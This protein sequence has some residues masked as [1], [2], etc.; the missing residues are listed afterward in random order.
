MAVQVRIQNFQSLK[1][2]G[3]EISGFTALSGPNNSGKTALMRA[4]QGVFQNTPGTSFVRHGAAEMEVALSFSD[5]KSVIWKKGTSSRSKP[6]YIINGGKPIHPGRGIPEEVSDLGVTP[7]KVMGRDVWPSLAP[8]FTGQVF[9]L[10]QPGSALAEAVADV[11]RVA[12]L[13]GALRSADR[14]LRSCTSKLKVRREDRLHLVDALQAFDGLDALLAQVAAI[15]LD[16]TRA[17]KMGRAVEMMREYKARLDRATYQVAR[18]SRIED[19]NIPHTIDE[20]SL[21]ARLE[22][23]RALHRLL[24]VNSADLSSLSGIEDVDVPLVDHDEFEGQLTSLET[25]RRL[26]TQRLSAKSAAESLAGVEGVK[27]A[28]FDFEKSSKT[29][30]VLD[31]LQETRVRRSAALQRAAA[32]EAE[33][34]RFSAESRRV[35]E[36]YRALLAE[37]G[38]CPTCGQNLEG[39]LTG[40]PRKD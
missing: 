26:R 25:F 23:L 15:E 37:Y 18:L 30:E 9:L 35:S 20:V 12:K 27:V 10:D 38:Q 31:F 5:G 6:T 19:V 22:D 40:G 14:D 13:N 33:A 16:H 17:G 4:I 36:E 1:D 21:L 34:L 7:I 29:A 2:T 32:L 8:Q 3:L 24:S 39:R 11:D 28:D